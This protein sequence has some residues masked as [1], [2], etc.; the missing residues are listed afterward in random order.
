MG[1]EV[2]ATL[3][4][5]DMV[6]E[7]RH[8]EYGAYSIR[9]AYSRNIPAAIMIMLTLALFAILVPHIFPPAPVHI[10]EPHDTN[11]GTNFYF[12]KVS[13]KPGVIRSAR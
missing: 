10:T 1:T 9:R 5:D 13:L 7:N 8:K 12:E 2:I 6:F 4:W 3:S 11:G